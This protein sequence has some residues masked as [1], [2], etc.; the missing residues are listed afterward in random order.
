MA[1][2]GVGETQGQPHGVKVGLHGLNGIG[3]E[4]DVDGLAQRAGEL[5]HQTAG[6]AEETVFRFLGGAG[7]DHRVHLPAVEE[8]GE[9]APDEHLKGGGGAE[10]RA[11]GQGAADVGVK[12]ADLQSQLVEGGQHPAYQGFGRAEVCRLGGEMVDTHLKIRQNFRMNMHNFGT[13]RLK[14]GGDAPADGRGQNPT[15]L[16]VSM[17]AGK[18]GPAGGEKLFYHEEDS[19]SCPHNFSFHTVPE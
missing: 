3:L 18:L 2:A 8:H 9:D 4:I 16:V 14:I 11:G 13:I 1:A 19:F 17:V 7:D 10:P 5:A 15:V 12:A 6:L